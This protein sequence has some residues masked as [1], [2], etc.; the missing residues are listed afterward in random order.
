MSDL[1]A[2]HHVPLNFQRGENHLLLVLRALDPNLTQTPD[3]VEKWL[4]PLLP[5]CYLLGLIGL[6]HR[7]LPLMAWTDHS[8]SR[9]S[10]ILQFS[11]TVCMS[12]QCLLPEAVNTVMLPATEL[13]PAPSLTRKAVARGT[14]WT[15]WV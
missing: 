6:G 3:S 5:S 4:L 1:L 15:S 11:A 12:Q 7:S 10:H 13:G 9:F 14:T 8:S 2:V